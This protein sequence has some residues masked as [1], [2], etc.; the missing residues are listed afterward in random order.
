MSMRLE[1]INERESFMKT[2]LQTVFASQ[3][4]ELSNRMVNALENLAGI[5]KSDLIQTRSPGL[6]LNVMPRSFS[7]EQ[8]PSSADY[9]L[10]RYHFNGRAVV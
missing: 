10:Y 6:T 1:E 8:H 5:D 7:G 9:S 3:L 4:E 2:S